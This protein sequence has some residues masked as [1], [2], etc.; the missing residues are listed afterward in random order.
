MTAKR[1]PNT[2]NQLN[3][4]RFKLVT[5]GSH[6]TGKTALVIRFSKNTFSERMSA[7]IGAHFM[8]HTFEI[9]DTSIK[10]DSKSKHTI[11]YSIISMF[12]NFFV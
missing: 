3:N 8:N 2:F 10:L 7:T 12:I 9:E 4:N 1:P 6:C 5:L 11:K